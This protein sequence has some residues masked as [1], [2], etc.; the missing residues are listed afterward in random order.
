M[1]TR[2]TRDERLVRSAIVLA[3]CVMAIVSGW[4]VAGRL[5][6]SRELLVRDVRVE[7]NRY[8]SEAEVLALAGFDRPRSTVDLDRDVIVARLGRS[9][10]V[11]SSTVLR[12]G[13]D[14]VVL[15]L[16]ESV[17]R[18]V[19]AAPHLLLV[20][21]TGRVIDRATARDRALPLLTGAAR[22]VPDGVDADALDPDSADLARSLGE[23]VGAEGHAVVVDGGVVRDAVAALDSWMGLEGYA[24]SLSVR[25]IAWSAAEGLS[26][27][28]VSGVEIKIGDRDTAQRLRRA[29]VALSQASGSSSGGVVQRV[30]VRGERQAVLRFAAPVVEP[31]EEVGT[32]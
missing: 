29:Q 28:L 4:A 26:F 18:V 3:V 25:E 5:R 31:D 2:R 13:R 6:S 8:L 7:G 12:P 11:M 14:S 30:D 1:T 15:V 17:P 10:W 27:V 23:P 19:V 24:P 20:D 22:L 9:P 32:E 21:G 16:E